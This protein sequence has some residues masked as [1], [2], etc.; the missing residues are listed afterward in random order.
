[1]KNTFEP[2]SSSRNRWLC[3]FAIL[4]MV[5]GHPWYKAPYTTQPVSS[6]VTAWAVGYFVCYSIAVVIVT[7]L[8]STWGCHEQDDELKAKR[9]RSTPRSRRASAAV[10]DTA[11][12]SAAVANAN[13]DVTPPSSPLII[14]EEE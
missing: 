9:D 1:M 10:N 8:Y 5:M 12:V 7:Y 11:D 13:F 4:I 6:G 3:L 2:L 14:N